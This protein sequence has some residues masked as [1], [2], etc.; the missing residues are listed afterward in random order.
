[1]K[2]EEIL[3][4]TPKILS[5]KQREFYFEEGYLLIESI[6]KKKWLDI[7]RKTTDL[8]VEKS[9][10][11]SSSNDIFD[12]DKGHNPENPRL[13]RLSSPNDHH[14]NYWNY[15]STFLPALGCPCR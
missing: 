8:M 6:D 10:K 13:R 12:L 1:M 4:I 5:Q 3:K 15:A 9:K 14:E 11:L 7:L 2:S